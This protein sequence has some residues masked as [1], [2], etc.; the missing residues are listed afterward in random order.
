MEY[1]SESTKFES[2]EMLK[3]IVAE[4]SRGFPSSLKV[5]PRNWSLSTPSKHVPVHHSLSSHI[6]YCNVGLQVWSVTIF[7]SA[8]PTWVNVKVPTLHGTTVWWDSHT[9]TDNR[10]MVMT[11]NEIEDSI[12]NSCALYSRD[13]GRVLI[14]QGY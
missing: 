2:R 10:K 4:V 11:D 6:I 9:D 13:G 8:F 3:I 12:S 1:F 14:R 5:M 7:S